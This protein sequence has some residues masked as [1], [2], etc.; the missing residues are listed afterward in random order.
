MGKLYHL[1]V[2]CADASIITTQAAT[3]LVD[4]HQIEQHSH[5]LP[6]SKRLRAVFVTHQ[7]FDHYSGLAFL[8]QKGYSIEYLIY[9]PY[10]RRYGDNSVTLEEWNEFDGHRKY[11]EQRGTKCYPQYRQDDWSKPW[12][13]PDG[14]R[15]WIAGPVKSIATSDTRELH[16]ACLV[17]TVKMGKRTCCFTGDA[18]DT[19]LEYVAKNTTH[20]CDD[21]LHASHH[22]SINGAE[23][24]FIKKAN[25][26]YTVI[27][28]SSGVHDNVPHPT[29]MQRYRNHTKQK[30]YRT[31]DGGTITW[32]F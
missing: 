32:T 25:A 12:W 26:E 20:F 7:H 11:F 31:D 5:L 16:D 27:S 18:S 13:T 24:S 14:L 4:C 22:G 2:G 28:T 10:V 1:N 3:F 9:S 6:T 21:I 23:L 8:R 19:N 17:L 15:I 30:V 29:A